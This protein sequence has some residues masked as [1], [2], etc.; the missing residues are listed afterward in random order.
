MMEPSTEIGRRYLVLSPN[1]NDV[2][3]IIIDVCASIILTNFIWCSIE[4]GNCSLDYKFLNN[5]VSNSYVMVKTFI[6][7][8]NRKFILSKSKHDGLCFKGRKIVSPKN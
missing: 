7:H 2:M 5:I 3:S 6:E 8:F 1:F 4:G